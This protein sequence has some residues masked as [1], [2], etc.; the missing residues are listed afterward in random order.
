LEKKNS[1]NNLALENILNL[2]PLF[3]HSTKGKVKFH[4]VD[5][6]GIVH[7]LQYGYWLEW[8]R[9]E[10]LG[11]LGIKLNPM[12]YVSE[13]PVMVVHSEINYFNPIRFYEEYE[14]LSRI[15]F[16]KNSSLGFENLI[17]S[18]NKLLIFAKIILVYLNIHSQQPERIPDN[19][20][21]L[22]INFEGRDL[23]LID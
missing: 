21:K 4:E 13:L 14:I 5:S 12:T 8:A 7:N 3:K 6:Y 9:T 2:K 18:N 11:N 23:N 10:Y 15:S 16:I 20:R 17:F 22:I 19:V 1:E